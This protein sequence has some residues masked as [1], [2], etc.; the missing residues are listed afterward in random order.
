MTETKPGTLHAE[1]PFIT[2]KS[3]WQVLALILQTGKQEALS[4]LCPTAH[5]SGVARPVLSPGS[6]IPDL[7]P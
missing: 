7:F 5:S 6:L 3:L 4:T 2:V 1:S